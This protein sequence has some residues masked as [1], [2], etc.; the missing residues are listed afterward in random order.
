M[1]TEGRRKCVG[2][3]TRRLS[4]GKR[5]GSNGLLLFGHVPAIGE[6]KRGLFG[7]FI[8]RNRDGHLGIETFAHLIDD[9]GEKLGE[10]GGFGQFAGEQVKSRGALFPLAF[11]ILL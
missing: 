8:F 2:S 9:H 3:P 6:V 1:Q 11:R 7:F 4:M 5:P 10:V